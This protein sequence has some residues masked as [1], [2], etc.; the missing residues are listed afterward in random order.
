MLMCRGT[1]ISDYDFHKTLLVL[2]YLNLYKFRSLKVAFLNN[3]FMNI[4]KANY[5]C[6]L[7][8]S[9]IIDEYNQNT[10]IMRKL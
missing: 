10:D 8:N 3:F 7:Q 9:I 6:K 4:F 1:L 2:S 5:E